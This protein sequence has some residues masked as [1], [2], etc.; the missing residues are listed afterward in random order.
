MI[1]SSWEPGRTTRLNRTHKLS[2]FGMALLLTGIALGCGR[3]AEEP[4]ASR[5]SEMSK[6]L[7][8]QIDS[9]PNLTSAQKEA[10]KA[11]L[12]KSSAAKNSAGQ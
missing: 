1:V 3:K 5:V 11:V 6:S 10:Y 4:T 12:R 7:S 8:S 2:L 9:N